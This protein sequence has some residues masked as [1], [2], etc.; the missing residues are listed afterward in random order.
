M[1]SYNA[2]KKKKKFRRVYRADWF[3][4]CFIFLKLGETR[5]LFV[6]GVV[7][8]CKNQPDGKKFPYPGNCRKYYQCKGGI[9]EEKKCGF[10]QEFSVYT[11]NCVVDLFSGC[12]S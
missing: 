1:K 3:L 9:A 10:L 12:Q 2:K 7:T 8:S 11:Y 6:S 5:V 4:R